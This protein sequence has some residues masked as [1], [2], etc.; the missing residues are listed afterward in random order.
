[1]SLEERIR[2]LFAHHGIERA[3]LVGGGIVSDLID[4]CVAA[5]DLAASLTLISPMMVPQTLTRDLAVPLSIVSGDRG[6]V[7]AMIDRALTGTTAPHRAVLRDY[8]PLLWTD[9]AVDRSAEIRGA[10]L[11]FL[12]QVDQEV[13]LPPVAPEPAAGNIAGI[14]YQVCGKGPPLVLFPL[15][16]SPSQWQPLLEDLAGRYAVHAISGAHIQPTSNLETRASNPGYQAVDLGHGSDQPRPRRAA[17]GSG[18]RL[19]RHNSLP[20][21]ANGPIPSDHGG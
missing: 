21:R 7:A 3:H 5:P 20:R 1:M 11:E 10:L 9:V 17:A 4:L 18:L 2:A 8:E 15:G 6:K 16:L 12:T 14:A 13:D 19:R